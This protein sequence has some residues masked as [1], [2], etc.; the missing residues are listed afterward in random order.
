MRVIEVQL[1]A[2]LSLQGL[3]ANCVEYMRNHVIGI[4]SSNTLVANS[5]ALN[6]IKSVYGAIT[7]S[8]A[9]VIDQR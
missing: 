7:V 1:R 2:L 4:N 5:E 8:W 9:Q 3:V 6:E